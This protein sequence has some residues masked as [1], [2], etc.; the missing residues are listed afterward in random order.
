MANNLK[1]TGIIYNPDAKGAYNLAKK[2]ES[3]LCEPFLLKINELNSTDLTDV[4]FL[5]SIGGDGTLLKCA[6]AGAPLDIKIF[7]FNVGRLGYLAQAMPK[8]YKKVIE[9]IKNEKYKIDERL[10]LK[11]DCGKKT[12]VALNDVV[13]K[14]EV[15]SR[16]SI[17]KLYIND[18]FVSN[19]LADGLII[20]TPTGSTAYN[21][22]A[23]GPVLSPKIDAFTI[24]PICP[25]TL[26]VRPI[27]IHTTDKIRIEMSD[28][29]KFYVTADGQNVYEVEGEISIEKYEKKAKLITLDEEKKEFYD[30]LREKLHWG[31]K[32]EK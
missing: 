2:L 20:S 22:S 8:D 16:T 19:Y 11:V 5:V 9:K 25:H 26:S 10:M 4:N 13:I 6:D 1:K 30:I 24:V 17:L 28:L 31:Q 21:L 14:G 23:G 32:P 15:F 27:V 18:I 3:N 12:F 7:G 29:D